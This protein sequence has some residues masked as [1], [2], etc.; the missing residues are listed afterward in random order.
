M[1]KELDDSARRLIR[2]AMQ[3]KGVNAKRLSLL[4]GKN[5]TYVQQYLTRGS[6]LS[7]P[8]D[9]RQA[10]ADQLGL[11][12]S[13]LK[14]P[15]R[16][17]AS[18]SPERSN[19]RI[20]PVTPLGGS[21]VRIPVYGQAMGG[22]DGR[23]ILNGAKVADALAPPD[24]V[25]VRDAYAVYVVG[26]SMEPRYRAGETVYVHPYMPVRKGDYVVVQLRA[27]HDGDPP[28]GYIKQ[29]MGRDDR[30][31]K[32]AQLNPRKIIEFPSE[33]VASV[34]RIIMAG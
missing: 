13:Q 24:L 9:A 31:L 32:L 8:E 21:G 29:F 18:R 5:E 23:F 28:E 11:A 7:L 3:Q 26:D 6:P 33:R 14:G 17:P 1:G 10:I 34:H 16:A 12:E 25:S 22:K 2:A 4:I 15:Q 27:Q 19:A 20:G 30:R